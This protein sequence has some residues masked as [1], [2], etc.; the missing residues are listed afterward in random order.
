MFLASQLDGTFIG[1][2]RLIRADLHRGQPCG[3]GGDPYLFRGLIGYYECLHALSPR[4]GPLGRC[5]P[6]G[7][8]RGEPCGDGIGM[9]ARGDVT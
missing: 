7:E 5:S 9:A 6:G 8:S 3:P 4:S 2:G 1:T